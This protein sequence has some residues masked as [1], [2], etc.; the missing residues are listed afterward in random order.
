MTLCDRAEDFADHVLDHYR[1][2]YHWGRCE[3]P[4]HVG[5]GRLPLCGA[6][7]QITLRVE[8]EI[9]EEAWFDQRGGCVVSQA[10][11]SALVERI[12]GVSIKEARSLTP[13]QH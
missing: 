1:D 9:I 6:M 3:S 11:A 12:E 10:A 8:N 2:P 13:Q 5:E 4:T 7:I